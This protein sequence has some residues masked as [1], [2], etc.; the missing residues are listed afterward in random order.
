[1]SQIDFSKAREQMVERH[2]AG[3]GIKDPAVLSAFRCVPRERFVPPEYQEDAYG[4]FPLPIGFEQTI[5]QPYI[6]ALMIEALS[7]TKSDKVLEIGAG[8]GYQTALLA[9]IASFVYFVERIPELAQRAEQ[10]LKELGYNNIIIKVADGTQGLPE[11]QPYDAVIVSAA[12][13]KVP[14][15]LLKQLALN[16]RMVIPV[17]SLGEQELILYRNTKSGIISQ[18]LGGVRFVP[19]ISSPRRDGCPC[20]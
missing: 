1:M 16:G 9:E 18:N 17:G 7:L 10:I 20:R 5:S 11:H 3:R 4:D 14:S 6:V 8:S 2:L 12:A 13:D 19:L 15:S